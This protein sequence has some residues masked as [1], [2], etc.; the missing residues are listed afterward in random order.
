[1]IRPPPRS[2][3][4]PYT[5]LFRS[6]ARY[7]RRARHNINPEFE[8]HVRMPCYS[9]LNRYK[10][11]TPELQSHSQLV[12]RLQLEKTFRWMVPGLVIKYSFNFRVSGTRLAGIHFEF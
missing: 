5:T 10:V 11:H 1:M 12:S 8:V 9:I 2:T 3:L 6:V 7:V 4:F